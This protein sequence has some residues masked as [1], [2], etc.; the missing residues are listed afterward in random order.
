MHRR[1]RIPR[2]TARRATRRRRTRT[3]GGT[4]ARTIALG[5]GL[6][7][8]LV[9]LAGLATQAYAI[10]CR[11]VS[12]SELK[13][14]RGN[15]VANKNDLNGRQFVK[16]L[17][18][19]K[20]LKH[21]AVARVIDVRTCDNT[22]PDLCLTLEPN[23]TWDEHIKIYK[24]R[25]NDPAKTQ[26]FNFTMKD[27][28]R[29]DVDISAV[30]KTAPTTAEIREA[31]LGAR[32]GSGAGELQALKT[33]NTKKKKKTARLARP[34]SGGPGAGA[35]EGAT[36]KCLGKNNTYAPEV[37][38]RANYPCWDGR[39]CSNLEN[40]EWT[41]Y[42]TTYKT[43]K[44]KNKKKE[45]VMVSCFDM[46]N[47]LDA[48]KSEEFPYAEDQT[49]RQLKKIIQARLVKEGREDPTK[50]KLGEIRQDGKKIKDDVLTS[51][52]EKNDG[53]GIFYHY[54]GRVRQ[55][56]MLPPYLGGGGCWNGEKYCS[57]LENTKRTTYNIE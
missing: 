5:V 9:G 47:P 53:N 19:D 31:R 6:T 22:E 2:R 11:R 29:I 24:E 20:H 51:D 16:V 8:A 40:T 50:A 28:R 49:V 52:L 36:K 38:K 18:H 17:V 34:R 33:T 35:G 46:Q 57:N 32:A 55:P 56:P 7:T 4:D 41:T 37:C 43:K 42:R 48:F 15:T 44:K 23:S 21:Y 54:Y 12:E 26:V 13:D 10:P 39:Y 1:T 45:K 25:K 30:T 3:R 27:D 14:N